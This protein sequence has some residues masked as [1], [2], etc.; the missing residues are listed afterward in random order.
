MNQSAKIKNGKSKPTERN[1]VKHQLH[2]L[3]GKLNYHLE[4]FGDELAKREKFHSVDGMDAIYLY[5]V[6]KYRW[7]PRDVRSLSFEDLR[8]LLSEEMHSWKLPNDAII[9]E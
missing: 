1:R 8:F 7:L 9:D 5:L 3:T 2:V 4:L 6:N